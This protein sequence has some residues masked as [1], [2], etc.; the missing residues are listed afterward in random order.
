[1][2]HVTLKPTIEMKQASGK[3]S[4]FLVT[5][6]IRVD[7]FLPRDLQRRELIEVITYTALVYFIFFI[8]LK[9]VLIARLRLSCLIY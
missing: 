1:M 7:I 2:T 6:L 5:L 8:V 3:G 9:L 4:F